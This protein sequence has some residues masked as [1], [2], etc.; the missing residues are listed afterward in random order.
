MS[1]DSDSN[2][3]ASTGKPSKTAQEHI[4]PAQV[5][6]MRE[7]LSRRSDQGVM[8]VFG[9]SANTWLKLRRGE[10]IRRSLAERL[11]ERLA[12]IEQSASH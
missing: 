6:R 7:M 5:E 11:R 2:M 12:R 3:S 10:P 4:L 9:I 1:M 8:D